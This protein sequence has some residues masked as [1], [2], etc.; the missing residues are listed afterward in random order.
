MTTVTLVYPYFR[1][2]NDNSIFRFP[3]L[4]SGYIAAYLKLHD[5]SVDLVDCTF[6]SQEEA[7]EKVRRSDPKI[8]G[9][10]SMFSMKNKTMQIA[11]LL[12]GNCELLIAGGPL[13]T[14]NPKDFLQ[15]FTSTPQHQKTLQKLN[16][17]QQQKKNTL[18]EK[19]HTITQNSKSQQ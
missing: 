13:P 11:K 3:P 9:I 5:I 12:R 7:L 17:T 2:Y 19:S 1:P 8:L 15:D 4:G 6:L 14:S 10:Y 18:S 16:T